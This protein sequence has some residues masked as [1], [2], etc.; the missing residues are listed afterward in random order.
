MHALAHPVALLRAIYRTFF[1]EG[2]SVHAAGLAF[3]TLL[4]LIPLGV[5]VATIYAVVQFRATAPE[6][7]AAPPPAAP[8]APAP[9]AGDGA[10]GADG[11]GHVRGFIDDLFMPEQARKA[12]HWIEQRI[13][14]L[15]NSSTSV[16][17]VGLLLLAAT[18]FFLFRTVEFVLNRI[19]HVRAGR[20]LGAQ[21]LTFWAFLTLGP[22]LLGA[23]VYGT[24]LLTTPLAADSLP[25]SLP[26]L[27]ALRRVALPAIPF[28]FTWLGFFL[29]NWLAPNTHVRIVPAL[30]GAL[31]AALLWEAMKYGFNLWLRDYVSYEPVYGGL[32]AGV[33]L[34]VWLYLS[35][36]L[37]LLGATIA[38]HLQ[39]PPGSGHWPGTTSAPRLALG[40]VAL[41]GE[42][43]ERGQRPPPEK[44][45]SRRLNSP[46]GPLREVA[47]AL[48]KAGI[49]VRADA[50]GSGYLP[51]RSPETIALG[52]VYAAVG[53]P[54][55]GRPA[56]VAGTSADAFFRSLEDGVAAALGEHTVADLLRPFARPPESSGTPQSA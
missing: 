22:L 10:A 16:T 8:S 30:A 18:A 26:V 47:D 5:V 44:V 45:L 56:G 32:A 49:L 23:S 17:I 46:V 50:K 25:A 35:W 40:L 24:H 4:G 13:R 51:A 2:I 41:V 27:A 6:S 55:G 20:A 3:K 42:A 53:D 48:L 1:V 14:A 36:Y 34:L 21:I 54:V 33:I 39:Y 37:A 38:F 31:V 11:L 28:L 29:L 9:A 15:R 12:T 7:E 43:F 19:Y 52:A